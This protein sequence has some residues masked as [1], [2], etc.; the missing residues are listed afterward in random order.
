MS[1]VCTGG[2]YLANTSYST[3]DV[4][5]ME[6]TP[7]TFACW[8]KP[9]SATPATSRSI[10]HIKPGATAANSAYGTL[11]TG[12]NKYNGGLRTTADTGVGSNSTATATTDWTH[13]CLVGNSDTTSTMYIN[14]T[15]SSGGAASQTSGTATSRIYVGWN[16]IYNSWEGKFAHVAV[17]NKALSA[18]DVANLLLYDPGSLATGGGVTNLVNYWALT[19]T[20]LTDSINSV[21]LGV[22][23][24]VNHDA[25][26][27]PTLSTYTGASGVIPKLAGKFG[28]VF[29]KLI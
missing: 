2:S 28:G 18:G 27:D 22:S 8:L 23:G 26:D 14:G 15:A 17:F 16:S 6:T 20:S 25:G 19:T 1:R 12:T 29:H 11:I 4:R 21:V 24:T 7:F 13:Y 5:A 9:T 10:F 3:I